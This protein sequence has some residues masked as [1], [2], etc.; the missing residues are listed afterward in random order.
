MPGPGKGGLGV[1]GAGGGGLTLRWFTGTIAVSEGSRLFRN[2][3]GWGCVYLTLDKNDR[4]WQSEYEVTII[5]I[6]F[7]RSSKFRNGDIAWQMGDM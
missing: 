6:V 2:D 3:G 4:K 7:E 5:L 1:P